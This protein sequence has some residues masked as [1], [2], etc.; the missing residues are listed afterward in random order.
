MGVV[1]HKQGAGGAYFSQSQS[2]P[3]SLSRA[4]TKAIRALQAALAKKDYVEAK[5]ALGKA[6]SVTKFR[7]AKYIISVHQLQLGEATGDAAMQLDAIDAALASGEVPKSAV[8]QL[9]QMRE[10]L[11]SAGN[12]AQ[13][14]SEVKSR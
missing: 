13:Q 1:S 6:Q 10:R 5:A 14:G 9:H 4:E 11:S 2:A 3:S 7:Q 12:A 8:P